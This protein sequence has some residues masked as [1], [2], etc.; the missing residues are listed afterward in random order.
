[1]KQPILEP[2]FVKFIPEILEDGKIYISLEYETA[3]HLCPCGCGNQVVTPI[4][5]P[6]GW[7]LD[8]IAFAS[9]Y[10]YVSLH[11]S[12]G[13]FSLPCKSHYFITNNIVKWC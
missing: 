12:I 3:I 2:V 7:K 1:M 6:K 13:S 11:P 9:G 4:N 5:N 8:V 10:N